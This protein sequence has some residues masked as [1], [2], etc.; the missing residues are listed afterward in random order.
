MMVPTD[1]PTLA[2]LVGLAAL[3]YKA[4][5]ELAGMRKD[6]HKIAEDVKELSTL[7][8]RVAAL[9]GAIKKRTSRSR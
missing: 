8:E 6:I 4:G 7:P 9:E 1:Y 3:V 2:A 5:A